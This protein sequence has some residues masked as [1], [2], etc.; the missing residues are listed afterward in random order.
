M[1]TK[2]FRGQTMHYCFPVKLTAWLTVIILIALF[3]AQT[4]K[5]QTDSLAG[6]DEPAVMEEIRQMGI[7]QSDIPGYLQYRKQEYIGI[8]YGT[9]NQRIANPPVQPQTPCTNMDFETGNLSGW[10]GTYGTNPGCTPTCVNTGM[11]AGRHTIMTG[12]GLDPCG[13]FPVVAP[14]GSFSVRLGNNINGGQAEQLVQTFTVTVPTFVYQYAVVMQDPGHNAVDQPYFQVEM[15]DSLGLPINCANITYVAGPNI[16]GFFNSACPQTVYRPW[17]SVAVDLTLYVGSDVTIRFTTADCAQGG[18]YGY[19]YID[20]TCLIGQITQSNALCTNGATTLCAP[21]GFASYNWAPG[22]Q[23]TQCITVNTPG[24]Y[25]VTMTAQG[26][27]PV[28]PLSINIQQYPAPTLNLNST[29]TTCS[30]CNGTADA[31]VAGGNTPYTYSW[32]PGAYTTANLVNLCAGNYTCIVTT[33]D[34]CTDTASTLITNPSNFLPSG[35]TSSPPSCN[36]GNN[37]TATITAS[38]G[39]TPYTYL[40]ANGQTTQTA[41]G[42]TAGSYSV[43]VTDA[44]GCTFPATVTVTQPAP[45]VPISVSQF[46]TTCNALCN[47][48]ADIFMGGGNAPFTYLWSDGQTT[49]TASNLCP[50]NYSVTVTD[51]NGCTGTQTYTITQPPPI[52]ITSSVVNADCAMSNGSAT[53]TPTGGVGNYTYSWNTAPMQN[54]PTASNLSAGTYIVTITDGNNCMNTDT[55][56]VINPNAPTATSSSTNVSCFG[57]ADGTATGNVNGG[58]APYTY[59]WNST[60]AQNTLTANTLPAGSYTLTVTDDAGCVVTTSVSLTEPP[61]IALAVAGFAETCTNSC[62]GQA[63]VIPSGGVGMYTFAWSPSGGTNPGATGLCTGIYTV[64][65]TDGNGCVS[66]DTAH[67]NQPPPV[68]VTMSSTSSICG[69]ATASATATGSGGAGNFTYMWSPGAQT[70]ST[71]SNLATGNY[72]VTATDQNGCAITDSV[73]VISTAPVL[74]AASATNITCNGL[75]DGSAGVTSVTG[76]PPYNYLWAPGGNTTAS[77]TNLCAGNYLV[78]VTDSNGC[79]D[80]VQLTVVEP[81]LLTVTAATNPSAICIGQSATLSSV[82]AGGTGSYTYGWSPGNMTGNSVNVTPT[83]TNQYTVGVTD[84]NGC[85]NIDTVTVTVNGLPAVCLTAGEPSGCEPFCVQFTNCSPSATN[86]T[87]D[88]GDGNFYTGCTPPVHCYMDPGTY[89][90]QLTV[91]DNNGC[92]NS[93]P[94]N[95]NS[96]LVYPQ[97]VAGFTMSTT[98][99]SIFEPVV[100]FTDQS[101]GAVNWLWDFGDPNDATTSTQQNPSHAYSDTG[102]FCVRLIVSS[103]DNCTDTMENCLVVQPEFTFFIPNCFTPDGDG[104]NEYFNGSGIG[105][106]K[107]Q[108]WIFDRWGNMIY[109]TGE[110]TNPET[111]I[112]WD[113]KANGGAEVAQQDVYV[114]RVYLTDVFLRTHTYNGHVSLVK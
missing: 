94:A 56:T 31:I 35:S 85:T 84:A 100:F 41:T 26:G 2:K 54:T 24:N 40:W 109:T 32:S 18:H 110:T 80:S 113:G 52:M 27:C 83:S 77:V 86:C 73:T 19:A 61:A 10:S 108:L 92:V 8:K 91:T 22:G 68:A 15:F 89:A 20:G 70:T 12:A 82:A 88:F 38:G 62:D 90:V 66:S 93:S 37:G 53:A 9:W 43:V 7:P 34:G 58:T 28:L 105:I 29:N 49:Q 106:V 63:V 45:V 13:G 74:A 112:P 75:C 98:A 23:T 87:W 6:F 17:T 36:G 46:N 4:L 67:V 81:P 101:T 48:S 5:A 69:S 96:I 102:M 50:G 99:T 11:I 47:G 104:L 42:L 30:A 59:S 51:A 111:A 3:S 71:I 76:T 44:N 60:P 55:V 57:G 1:E 103:P 95:A 65:V 21:V 14:G 72:I 39:S 64:T 33:V 114:W 107:Y 25:Q 97:P 79:A 78:A 16:P